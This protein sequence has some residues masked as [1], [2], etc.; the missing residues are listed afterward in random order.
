MPGM[1]TLS[2][3]TCLTTLSDYL[4]QHTTGEHWIP[5]KALC[6]SYGIAEAPPNESR[7]NFFIR[8]VSEW[9]GRTL[10]EIADAHKAIAQKTEFE[11]VAEICE[12][13]A[14]EI[15]CASKAVLS[16]PLFR[17]I[18][19][20]AFQRISSSEVTQGSM[21][22]TV[23]R[24]RDT[25]KKLNEIFERIGSITPLPRS[26]TFSSSVFPGT[27][28]NPN[29]GTNSSG[30]FLETFA[31]TQMIRPTTAGM[32]I[33]KLVR[34]LTNNYAMLVFVGAQGAGKTW[35]A[36][37]LVYGYC[38]ENEISLKAVPLVAIEPKDVIGPTTRS[39]RIHGSDPL[40]D[41]LALYAAWGK[42]FV[43]YYYHDVLTPAERE[44]LSRNSQ[45]Q[46]LQD[47]MEDISVVIEDLKNIQSNG[48]RRS[49]VTVLADSITTVLGRC[50]IKLEQPLIG[51][52]GVEDIDSYA[53][54]SESAGRALID[55]F[56]RSLNEEV[57]LHARS[58]M[59]PVEKRLKII[60]TTRFL[61]MPLAKTRPPWI[62]VRN[63]NIDDC[64]E[65]VEKYLAP[66]IV[67]KCAL[68]K[69]ST[70]AYN[71]T[72]GYP[73]FFCR[74]LE[75]TLFV[76]LNASK[77][78]T[79]DEILSIVKYSSVFWAYDIQFDD[80]FK[81]LLEDSIDAEL[82]ESPTDD[83]RF[84]APIR[85]AFYQNKD[86]NTTFQQAI[87]E[88]NGHRQRVSSSGIDRDILPLVQ[89][90]LLR[91]DG[92]GEDYQLVPTNDIVT[93][94][95]NPETLRGLRIEAPLKAEEAGDA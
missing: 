9:D 37:Q 58:H 17:E 38:E 28:A 72:N 11:G 93:M 34:R 12:A 81:T 10:T 73:W 7:P 2:E 5:F 53:F 56:K 80:S 36:H 47:Y 66:H 32:K 35:L 52:L 6:E 59:L 78:L 20:A 50:G 45:V 49:I 15:E 91:V 86:L 60:V 51:V 23:R 16:R 87:S 19:F 25:A 55:S 48:R 92:Q 43:K 27:A 30:S 75:A 61:E 24:A 95:F 71:V 4:K 29:S 44:G 68:S 70:T 89:L 39:E 83:S 13:I 46:H 76:Y 42:K 84:L 8:L 18:V 26:V 3:K 21:G 74:Y 65:F 33:P 64:T 63:F 79:L 94:Y 62:A 85:M 88:M 90:G 69:I 22:K 57:E 31:E 77:T 67:D 82:P 54:E 41:Y 40:T 14:A 1:H